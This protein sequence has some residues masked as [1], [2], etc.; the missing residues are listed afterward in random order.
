MPWSEKS[1]DEERALYFIFFLL[2]SVAGICFIN[3][4]ILKP[5]FSLSR[6]VEE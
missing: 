6:E 5:D 3:P 1:I 4:T 2:L